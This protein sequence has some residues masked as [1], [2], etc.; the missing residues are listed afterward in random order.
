MASA[1]SKRF[2]PE[3]KKEKREGREGGQIIDATLVPAPQQ[4]NSVTRT[5][6]SRE[7][8]ETIKEG[9]T[10]EDWKSKL[11]RNRQTD[12]DARWTK[13]HE[14]SYFGN[15]AVPVGCKSHIGADRRHKF[16]RRSAVSDASVHDS[17]K[18]EDILDTRNT[19]SDGWAGS[20]D[21]SQEI[22][23]KLGRR[24]PK[25][26][27]HRRAYRNRKLSEA[28]KAANT[29]RSKVR[30]RVEHVFGDQKNAMGAGIVRTIGIVRARCKI[31]MTNLV[32]NIRRFIIL[33]RMAQVARRTGALTL[34]R[35]VHA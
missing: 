24:G 18:F 31:G 6:G 8:N 34:H 22:E 35:R 16:V 29:T 13:K 32:Y 20:G 26:R 28:Q 5:F 12:K 11:A 7:E 17:Q 9:E 10:P 27:I 25:S 30:A 19:A 14:R 21:R 15:Q 4:Q 1:G 33:E 23:E 3:G 2:S